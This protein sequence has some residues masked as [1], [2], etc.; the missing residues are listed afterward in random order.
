MGTP[1]VDATALLAAA[2]RGNVAS[3]RLV[4]DAGA[5]E[6]LTVRSRNARGDTA[7]HEA[8]RRSHW[9]LVTW[10]I[11]HGA[12]A[13][14]TNADGA[15]PLDVCEDD[16]VA[17][18]TYAAIMRGSPLTRGAGERAAALAESEA[19]FRRL[20]AE[21]PGPGPG[22]GTETARGGEPTP[23]ELANGV[24]TTTPMGGASPAMVEETVRRAREF[25]AR[26]NFA[27]GHHQFSTT[28]SAAATPAAGG[29]ATTSRESA[30]ERELFETRA[31]LENYSNE[32]ENA[33]NVE[34]A[35][36]ERVLE[37]GLQMDRPGGFGFH[38]A[39]AP[40]VP[41]ADYSQTAAVAASLREQLA[42]ANEALEKLKAETFGGEGGT[43]AK[44]G[45]FGDEDV[46]EIPKKLLRETEDVIL[47]KTKEVED[48]RR[49]IREMERRAA[50]SGRALRR[51]AS[52]LIEGEDAMDDDADDYRRVGG[53]KKDGDDDDDDGGDGDDDDDASS[54]VNEKYADYLESLGAKS[55]LFTPEKSPRAG[56]SGAGRRSKTDGRPRTTRSRPAMVASRRPR[57]P[58]ADVPGLRLVLGALAERAERD[59]A[60]ESHPWST[61]A[62]AAHMDGDALVDAVAVLAAEAR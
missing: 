41:G 14:A 19:S 27:R 9:P 12:D 32:L 61:A 53:G 23:K 36:H 30:L 33:R 25:R 1:A 26:A 47:R 56:V 17:R 62:A 7:L 50:R 29:L 40:R 44:F 10:L 37:E 5:S 42:A 34:S 39:R 57:A 48:A 24:T 4:L 46:V 13:E 3:V 60:P 18:E 52:V 20:A 28:S 51:L 58:I 16:E 6:G 59:D 31:L 49:E 43:A 54:V 22:P 15:T 11:A 45:E 21:R 8:T 55:V 38:S 2:A 35:L